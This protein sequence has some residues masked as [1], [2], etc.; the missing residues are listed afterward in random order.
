M[1]VLLDSSILG[2]VCNPNN[3]PESAEVKKWLFKLLSRSFRVVSSDICDYEIRRS[4]LLVQKK[5]TNLT[6]DTLATPH[7]SPLPQGEREQE[8]SLYAPAP[9]LPPWE[10]GLGDEGLSM[11]SMES[12]SRF[13]LI[14]IFSMW[15]ILFHLHLGIN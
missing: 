8:T 6:R 12:L 9:L 10:K 4:L 5:G 2:K 15:L 7:P 13:E 14:P 1:I 11:L 3:T